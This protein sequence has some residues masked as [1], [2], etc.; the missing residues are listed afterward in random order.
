MRDF[1]TK[2][3]AYK[4]IPSLMD[5]NSEIGVMRSLALFQNKKRHLF[6]L[7]TKE[8]KILYIWFRVPCCQPPPP[9]P[10]W[11][12][13]KTYVLATFSW[14]PP[15]HMSHGIYNV[16]TSSASETVVFAAFCNT[17]LHTTTLIIVLLLLLLRLRINPHSKS[18]PPPLPQGGGAGVIF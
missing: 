9:H 3:F 17:T 10:P 12:G 7:Q 18:S 15:K 16:L 13:S 11:Y 6:S 4:P 14:N 1:K 5:A 2:T 8:N